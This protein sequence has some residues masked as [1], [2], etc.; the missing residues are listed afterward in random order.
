LTYRHFKHTVHLE[1]KDGSKI[2]ELA[3]KVKEAINAH[4]K[5]AKEQPIFVNFLTY[6]ENGCDLAVEAFSNEKDQ[7]QFNMVQQELLMKIHEAMTG[8]NMETAS[9]T[10][11]LKQGS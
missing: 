7:E 3:K 1:F 6:G 11:S 2:P 10:V 9:L 5:I 4:P 8:L